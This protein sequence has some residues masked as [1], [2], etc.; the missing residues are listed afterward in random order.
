[1]NERSV[2][3]E[4]SPYW[5]NYTFM[6]ATAVGAGAQAIV[7]IPN[8]HRDFIITDMGFYSSPVGIPATGVPYRISIQDNTSNRLLQ[9]Q[10]FNIMA[11][12]GQ[13]SFVNDQSAWKLPMPYKWEARTQLIVTFINIGT[14]ASTPE[15]LL[16][17]YLQ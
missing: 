4:I 5:Y 1:M 14:L 12:T 8:G 3:V 15:L 6:P 13:Y 17:G 7:S 16:T 2:N 9:N 10:P 11:L